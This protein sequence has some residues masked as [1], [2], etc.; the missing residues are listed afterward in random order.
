M[1]DLAPGATNGQGA[2]ALAPYGDVVSY[3]EGQAVLRVPKVETA[4]VTTQLL[5]NFP[6]HDLTIQDPPIEE[7][8]SRYLVKG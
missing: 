2:A 6:I 1:V 8:L 7:V 5:S 4:V 3:E